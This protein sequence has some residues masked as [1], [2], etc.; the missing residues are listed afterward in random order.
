MYFIFPQIVIKFDIENFLIYENQTIGGFD[1]P[2]NH[3]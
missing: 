1:P 3:K 2:F